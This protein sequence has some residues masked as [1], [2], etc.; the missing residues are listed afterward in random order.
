[1]TFW[2]LK[3]ENTSFSS[4]T[5]MLEHNKTHQRLNV[6]PEKGG[7]GKGSKARERRGKR[8]RISRLNDMKM[9]HTF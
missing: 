2:H 4:P 5:Q 3:K 6:S 7:E 8:K 1:M 9:N